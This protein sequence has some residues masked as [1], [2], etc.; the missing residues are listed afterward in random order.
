LIHERAVIDFIAWAPLTGCRH[1]TVISRVSLQP[2]PR[3]DIVVNFTLK[4]AR[5]EMILYH[6]LFMPHRGRG[7]DDGRPNETS[8][9]I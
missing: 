6:G 9:L 7:A 4:N 5:P 2:G 8:T 1:E 3:V